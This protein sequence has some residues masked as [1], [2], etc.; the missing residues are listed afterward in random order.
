IEHY[1]GKFPLWLAPEQVRI[2]TVSDRFNAYAD[3]V[4]EKLRKNSIRVEVDKRAES[5]PKK[6]REAQIQY[7]PLIVTVGEKEETSNTLAVRTL[8]GNVKYGMKVDEFILKVTGDIE[9]RN[10][11]VEI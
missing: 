11:K 8:D 2:V 9:E 4:A 5:I 1:A 3:E 10:I 7:V 6:V